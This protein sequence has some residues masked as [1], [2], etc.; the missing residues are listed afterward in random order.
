MLD[1]FRGDSSKPAGEET[2]TPKVRTEHEREYMQ[3]VFQLLHDWQIIPG[4]NT[5]GIVEADALRAWVLEARKRADAVNRRVVCDIHLG[6]V[7]AQS[8]PDA[9]NG[10]PLVA[11]REVFEECK[12]DQME[13]GFYDGL[14]NLRG[15]H[16]RGLYEGGKQER[17]LA[18]TFEQHAQTCSKWPRTAR[19]LRWVAK[20]YL[21]EAEL[22]DERA[23]DQE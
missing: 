4:T 18:A 11:I 19:A 17:D 9:D 7:F 22:E 2:E 12:S 23:R 13:S 21:R 3:R 1:I 14:R 8:P 5:H 6:K 20:F 16:W 10:M 15:V